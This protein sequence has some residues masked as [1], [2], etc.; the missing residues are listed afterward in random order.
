[1]FITLP[2]SEHLN[3]TKSTLVFLSPLGFLP[4]EW[5]CLCCA[6]ANTFSVFF[7]PN[8]CDKCLF[9]LLSSDWV[10]E[11][12]LCSGCLSPGWGF[13]LKRCGHGIWWCCESSLKFLV[14]VVMW[15]RPHVCSC[16][17]FLT[18]LLARRNL[19]DR[20]TASMHLKSLGPEQRNTSDG[21]VYPR[22][23]S[24]RSP[25]EMGCWTLSWEIISCNFFSHP[26]WSSI[27]VQHDPQPSVS[28]FYSCFLMWQPS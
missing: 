18:P 11:K 28:F 21:V 23:T 6:W 13:A 24:I 7:F 2:P 16:Q 22:W 3:G 9:S 1:M 14:G 15:F 27:L 4:A 19:L 17:G 8:V 25:E 10:G 26:T 20:F 12:V 5:S